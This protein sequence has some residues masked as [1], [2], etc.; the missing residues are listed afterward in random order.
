MYFHPIYLPAPMPQSLPTI[1]Q[2]LSLADWRFEPTMQEG[3]Q[4]GFY[5]LSSAYLSVLQPL[6]LI[7]P[8]VPFAVLATYFDWHGGSAEQYG[9]EPGWR[10]LGH[11]AL[12]EVAAAPPQLY[13]EAPCAFLILDEQKSDDEIIDALQDFEEPY[14]F[15]SLSSDA[16]A[17]WQ[18]LTAIRPFCYFSYD[19]N[20]GLT[21]IVRE[22]DDYLRFMDRLP[23]EMIENT[24]RDGE[25]KRRHE[26]VEDFGPELG[27]EVCSVP[28]CDR[29]RLKSIFKCFMHAIA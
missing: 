11:F 28:G 21:L 7:G 29:L 4:D 2:Y 12:S 9:D 8:T 18:A 5:W 17:F 20:Q 16:M 3:Q 1:Q 24:C 23:W 26:A 27:P 14:L 22:H 25:S 19:L 10:A 15:W 6:D 13:T